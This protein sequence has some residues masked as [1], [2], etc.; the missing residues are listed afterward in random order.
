MG[1]GAKT[2]TRV[3][4]SPQARTAATNEIGL[5]L[6]YL[7]PRQEA[8]QQDVV[9]GMGG[10]LRETGAGRGLQEALSI[11]P[12]AVKGAG[13]AAG[14]DAGDMGGVLDDLQVGRQAGYANLAQMFDQMGVR[15]DSLVDPRFAQFLKPET[16]SSTKPGSGQQAATYASLAIAAAGIAIAI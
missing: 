13:K 1:G 6:D 15:T 12:V 10:D 8:L 16:E 3:K 14:M 2:T 9:Q 4:M 11:A 7:G 5:L